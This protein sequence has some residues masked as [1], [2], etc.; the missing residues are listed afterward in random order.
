MRLVQKSILCA[1][2]ALVVLSGA[3]RA[4]V[5][6]SLSNDPGAGFAGELLGLLAGER[7]ALQ[8]SAP[9]I[10]RAA[11]APDASPRPRHRGDDPARYDADWLAGLPPAKGGAEWQC[12]AEAIYFEA[13]GES[14][15]GQFAVAEVILNRVESP[16][17]PGTICGVVHQGAHRQ[18]GCQ[19]SYACD[20]R[21]EVIGDAASWDRAGK[22]AR[23]MLDSADRPLTEGATHFHT[24]AVRPVWARIYEHTARIGAHLFYRQTGTKAPAFGTRTAT[25]SSKDQTRIATIKGKVRLDMGL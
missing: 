10:T 7:S 23:L 17:Y 5:R 25:V 8:A 11:V 13:R 6:V 15:R 4:E 1:A 24:T 3:A 19:F 21:P 2:A 12:L 22:I 16:R 14:L 20:G 18:G 9:T